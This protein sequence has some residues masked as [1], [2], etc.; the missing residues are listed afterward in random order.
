MYNKSVFLIFLIPGE[1]QVTIEIQ[2]EYTRLLGSW[3]TQVE[4]VAAASAFE[5]PIN[6]YYSIYKKSQKYTWKVVHP[7]SNTK[8][9]LKLPEFPEVSEGVSLQ[10]PTHSEMLYYDSLHYDAVVCETTGT[11]CS[12]LGLG[13][14]TIIS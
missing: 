11:V 9:K 7:Y 3:E 14:I 1:N 4:V 8:Q 10:M 5:I 2:I 13:N 6:S 12:T